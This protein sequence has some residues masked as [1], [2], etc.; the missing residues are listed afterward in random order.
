M[1]WFMLF[2]AVYLVGWVVAIPFGLR[3]RMTELVCRHCDKGEKNCK[4]LQKERSGTVYNYHNI[5]LSPRGEVRARTSKDV[6]S[7]AGRALFWPFVLLSW[8]VSR[9]FDLLLKVT[10]KLTPLTSVERA[11]INR[12]LMEESMQREAKI[13]AEQKR[14]VA[15]IEGRPVPEL[16]QKVVT[17]G[18]QGFMPPLPATVPVRVNSI[19]PE[20]PH[21]IH[22]SGFESYVGNV[23]TAA[24]ERQLR[25]ALGKLRASA[26]IPPI[27]T[28]EKRLDD[29][30]DAADKLFLL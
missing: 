5:N 30:D 12:G 6:G 25:E 13:V 3:H 4:Q 15:E 10:I 23:R 27:I 28:S 16:P 11:R 14:L 9:F 21:T 7:S 22:F 17:T 19:Q 8:L 18:L 20:K 26:Q 24:Y 29:M 2:V 1:G